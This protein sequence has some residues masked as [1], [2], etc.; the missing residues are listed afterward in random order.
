MAIN[1]HQI[2]EPAEQAGD[3]SDTAT[4][5]ATEPPAAK[6]APRYQA[7]TIVSVYIPEDILHQIDRIRTPQGRTRSDAIADIL[8]QHFR[9]GTVQAS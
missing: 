7:A 1:I 5:A 2:N 6:P 8:R 4:S 9:G 3:R